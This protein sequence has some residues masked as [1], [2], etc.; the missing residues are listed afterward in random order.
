MNF[1]TFVVLK[2]TAMEEKT[3]K[4]QT[5]LYAILFILSLGVG[6]LVSIYAVQFIWAVIPFAGLFLVKLLDVI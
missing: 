1:F 3:E 2:K 5:G 6:A 4:K